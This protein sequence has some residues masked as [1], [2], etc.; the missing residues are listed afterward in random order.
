MLIAGAL[1]CN[2][3]LAAAPGNVRVSRAASGLT[4]APVVN[5]SQLCTL[6]RE[7][8]TQRVRALPA[9]SMHA[10]DEGRRLV[11]GV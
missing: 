1:A 11:V 6:D 10:V 8:L 7:L 5:A 2:S 9:A 4:K 3:A